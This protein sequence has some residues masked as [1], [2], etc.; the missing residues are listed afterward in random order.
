M[1]E[2]DIFQYE[3]K[4]AEYVISK[5]SDKVRWREV[6]ETA[7]ECGDGQYAGDKD[8]RR[9]QGTMRTVFNARPRRAG[10][11]VGVRRAD[12]GVCPAVVGV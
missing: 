1:R 5:V 7:Q 3:P 6:K 11:A 9:D 12:A 2:M 10:F 4:G 8:C